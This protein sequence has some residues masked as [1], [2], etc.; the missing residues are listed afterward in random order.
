MD[1]GCVHVRV[2]VRSCVSVSTLTT[3]L[4]EADVD[5]GRQRQRQELQWQL[6]RIVRHVDYRSKASYGGSK[7][8]TKCG[9]NLFRESTVFDKSL[10]AG[11]NRIGHVA[12]SQSPS[13][14]SDL[15]D[16]KSAA[17]FVNSD[18]FPRYQKLYTNILICLYRYV[19][20]MY[21]LYTTRLLN[22]SA[23]TKRYEISIYC[24]VNGELFS[25]NKFNLVWCPKE[26]TKYREVVSDAFLKD[27]LYKRYKNG[28]TILEIRSLIRLMNRKDK[29]MA[30]SF[31]RSISIL[32]C[33]IICINCKM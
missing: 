13:L 14:E 25:L 15:Y 1:A 2:A 3:L 24:R 29:L 10:Y 4:Y 28:D 6:P 7:N 32:F 21:T 22:Y 12:L 30:S 27:V 20:Y 16:M 17:V 31:V 5:N 8:C 19:A 33:R 18:F 9:G 11:R 23:I 26:V